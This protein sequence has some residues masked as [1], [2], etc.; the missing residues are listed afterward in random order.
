MCRTKTKSNQ[1]ELKTNKFGPQ[2][3]RDYIFGIVVVA[4][5]VRF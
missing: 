1:I 4:N 3:L 2:C 5:L